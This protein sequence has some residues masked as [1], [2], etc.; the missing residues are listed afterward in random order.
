[1]TSARDGSREGQKRPLPRRLWIRISVAIAALALLIVVL[2][3]QRA[4]WTGRWST[5]SA[6]RPQIGLELFRTKGCAG[7]HA[8]GEG[9]K[10]SAP[11][12]AAETSSR[13]GPDQLVTVMWNHAPQMWER[14][15]EQKVA[16]PTFSQQEMADLLAYLYTLRYV[17]ETGDAARGGR[18]FESKGCQ[19]CHAV[20]GKGGKPL[21]G[22]VH[23][24][25]DVDFGRLGDGDVEPP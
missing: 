21:E 13:P 17:G 18:L 7:C 10:A 2:N 1:M 20:R 15:Q 24:R 6:G 23:A 19:A 11:D 12:L 5:L 4:R 8:P 16:P 22:S 9:V 14:M 3:S 25:S